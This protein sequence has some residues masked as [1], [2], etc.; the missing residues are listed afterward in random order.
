MHLYL[1]QH[2]EAL[3]KEENPS[4]NLS[5][6]GIEDIK[7]VASMAR[8]L[9]IEVRQ[10]IHS[11]K[12]RALQ[13]AQVLADHITVDMEILE[14][15]GLLPNDDP[16]IWNERISKLDNDIMLVGHLPHLAKLASLLI[17]GNPD[18]NAVDFEMGCIICMYRSDDGKWAVERMIKKG[19]IV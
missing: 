18:L 6:K 9:K 5:N 10:I 3:S 13:T 19:M 15:D 17:L 8:D 11:G 16:V 12:M 7:N 1:V 14:S 4:R 2:A